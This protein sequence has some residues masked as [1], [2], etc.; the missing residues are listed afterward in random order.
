MNEY[1]YDD[2]EDSLDETLNQ[3]K[4]G[5]K[6]A[7]ECEMEMDDYFGQLEGM[8]GYSPIFVTKFYFTPNGEEKNFA[9]GTL[10]PHFWH[11][12]KYIPVLKAIL[13][14]FREELEW[15]LSEEYGRYAASINE[16][17]DEYTAQL[18]KLNK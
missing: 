17:I 1:N 9:C 18:D 11:S 6:L 14:G 5:Y 7:I 13:A 3:V 2:F 15:A 4:N 12:R 10:D 16:H 8:P